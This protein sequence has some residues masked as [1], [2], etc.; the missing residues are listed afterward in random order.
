ME[1]ILVEPEARFKFERLCDS[2]HPE[3]VGGHFLG[4]RVKDKTIVK[5]VFPVPNVIDNSK[6]RNT[7]REHDWGDFWATTYSKTVNLEKLGK[8]H[9]HPNGAIPSTQD[10][11]ACPGLHMW[12]IHH[13]KG[14]HT[15]L[16]ARNYVNLEVILINEPHEEVSCPQIK[17]DKLIL[18]LGYVESSGHLEIN[19]VVNSIVSLKDETRKILLLALQHRGYSNR[20]DLDEVVKRSN[21]TK[22]TVRKHLNLCVKIGLLGPYW[23]RG[24]YVVKESCF[25]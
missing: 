13:N 16:A 3:E 15:F 4:V 12:L 1:K 21:R 24:Q 22:T 2:H 11:K 19:G 10:M 23:R 25:A 14:E 18:G 6:K 9:S 7:Y 20:V 8:F 17:G 5:E